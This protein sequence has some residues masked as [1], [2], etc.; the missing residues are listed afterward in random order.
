MLPKEITKNLPEDIVR[1][2]YQF[3]STYKDKYNLIMK[4]IDRDFPKITNYM[5]E[6]DYGYYIYNFIKYYKFDKNP[7]FL[8]PT[9]EDTF[10]IRHDRYK[11]AFLIAI[12]SHTRK[13]TILN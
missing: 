3:D 11:K 4:I 13:G 6:K 10:Y 2:I 8:I 7:V 12:K 1:N 5:L 9:I